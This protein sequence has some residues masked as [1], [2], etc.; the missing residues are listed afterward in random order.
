MAPV[1]FGFNL[2]ASTK[3]R[4]G[5]RRTVLQL[6]HQA[7]IHVRFREV[8]SERDHCLVFVL[9]SDKILRAMSLLRRRE[10]PLYRRIRIGRL[11]SRTLRRNVWKPKRGGQQNQ[12]PGDTS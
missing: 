8:R 7:K 2:S 6:I 9:R 1:R 10:V 11:H 3:F 5:F 4:H 12:K